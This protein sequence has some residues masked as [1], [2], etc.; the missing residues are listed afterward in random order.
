M[1]NDGGLPEAGVVNQPLPSEEVME[2]ALRRSALAVSDSKE[3]VHTESYKGPIRVALEK[4]EAK[5]Q[6]KTTEEKKKKKNKEKRA[7]G[8]EEAQ[9]RKEKKERKLSE[10]RERRREKKR[11]KKKEDKRKR[12]E[13]PEIDGKSTTARVDGG[14]QRNKENQH[15]LKRNQHK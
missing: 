14:C 15:N 1:E 12:A 2:E 3:T 4:V 9:P 8:D 7:E 6:P 5:K 13:S 10:K 11:L